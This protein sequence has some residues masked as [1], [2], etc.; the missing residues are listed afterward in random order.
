MSTQSVQQPVHGRSSLIGRARTRVL[1]VLMRE[2]VAGS[3]MHVD[4]EDPATPAP[5]TE[6]WTKTRLQAHESESMTAFADTMR[7]PAGGSVRDGVVGDLATYYKL[8][9]EQ[10]VRRCLHWEEESVN[11]WRAASADTREGLAQFYNS[12]TSWSFDLLWYSYLQTVGF[13]SP[14]HV[15]VADWLRRPETGARLLDFGSGV[16]V[17]AQLFGT[18]GY[19]VALAD[20]SAPLLEFARWRLER[21]GVKAAYL[22]LPAELPAASYDVITALDTLAHVPDAMQTA[23][24]L[25]AATRPGGLLVTNFDTRRKSERNAWHLYHDDLPLRWAI[26]RAGFV[27]VAHIDEN[28]WIYQARPTAGPAWRWHAASAWLRLASPPVRGLRAAQHAGARAAL[29][30]LARVRG[31]DE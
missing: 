26:E 13:A 18:L 7:P 11:E 1:T 2:S 23:R 8:T 12:V 3:G 17:A 22:R 9:P 5:S 4:P 15:V 19:D 21:R 28:L 27:P 16:G 29:V 14:K 6:G 10:V 31:L 30:A 24:E 25:Y 20:V